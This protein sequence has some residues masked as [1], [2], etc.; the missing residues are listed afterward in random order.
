MEFRVEGFIQRLQFR[1]KGLI[2]G[3]ELRIEGAMPVSL[4][5]SL[6]L[7]RF[8]PLPVPLPLPSSEKLTRR[9]QSRSRR[10]RGAG[11]RR[12]WRT[13]TVRKTPPVVPLR[14]SVSIPV[15][16]SASITLEAGRE[17]HG[18]VAYRH[19]A[20]TPTSFAFEHL[21][22]NR[23]CRE[24]VLSA[25]R[26]SMFESRFCQHVHLRFEHSCVPP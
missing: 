2:H 15:I 12:A 17:H 21:G 19:S 7:A 8:S 10:R 16:P 23:F 5:L 25:S 22:P 3:L 4:S 14:Y 20:N 11:S 6:S 1:V 13:A 24:Q 9:R 18:S 26:F